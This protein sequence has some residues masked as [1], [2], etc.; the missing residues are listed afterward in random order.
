MLEDVVILFLLCFDIKKWKSYEVYVNKE[1]RIKGLICL[2]DDMFYSER[3]TYRI[4]TEND[5]DLFY[6]LYS[7]GDVM[8]YAY[9]DHLKT[10]VEAKNAFKD[11]LTM[12]LDSMYLSMSKLL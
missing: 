5:F 1:C 9:R 2:E 3:L 6:E 4:L 8:R 7:N 10:L 12:Q 11:I